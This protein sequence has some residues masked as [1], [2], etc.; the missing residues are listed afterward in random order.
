MCTDPRDSIVLAMVL[1][2]FV[3]VARAAQT[4]PPQPLTVQFVRSIGGGPLPGHFNGPRGIAIDHTGRVFVADRGYC[5]IQVFDSNGHFLYMWGTR[6]TGPGAFQGPW[7]VALDRRGSVYVTDAGN[8]R[9]QVFTPDGTFLRAFGAK[10]RS[11][12]Q[13]TQPGGIAIDDEGNIFVSDLNDRVQMFTNDGS[14][15]RA[16]GSRGYGDGQFTQPS[17][18]GDTGPSGIAVGPNGLV[19]VADTW[20]SRVQVFAR[21]GE[22][23]GKF[24]SLATPGGQFNTP[25]AIAAGQRGGSL[26]TP[27]GLAIDADGNVFV[28]NEGRM[29]TRGAYN[30]QKFAA[31]GGFLQRWGHDGVAP[32]QFDGPAGIAVDAAGSFYVADTGNNRIQKFNKY[33]QLQTMW[34]S[35]GDGLL[36][37]P[38]GLAID[39]DGNLL[40][41]DQGNKQVQKFTPEGRFLARWGQRFSSTGPETFIFP[42]AVAADAGHVYVADLVG[43]TIQVF[44]PTGQLLHRWPPDEGR[45]REFWPRGVLLHDGLLIAFDI[46]QMRVFD[47]NGVLQARRRQ[48]RHVRIQ[49]LAIDTRGNVFIAEEQE[50]ADWSRVRVMSGE[51]REVA[52]WSIDQ[53]GEKV[54]SNIRITVDAAGRVFVTDWQRCRIR[55]FSTDGRPLG[56]WGTCGFENGQFDNIE[57]VIVDANGLVYVS[58]YLNNRVQVFKVS[59]GS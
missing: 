42:I 46:D 52:R 29:R 43:R 15:V 10:G 22:F 5:R 11:A 27:E 47:A 30:V 21:T 57:D 45:R 12:G 14:F 1:T 31:D 32:G 36:R 59:G 48:P 16:W 49:D 4:V 13:F 56:Q 25:A 33:G 8:H 53:P 18:P 58:D 44:D 20:N 9:V 50:D 19:Y 54:T 55:I 39:P 51:G 6:G 24:G 38:L 26:N 17:M 35:S 34:G 40:V 2:A 28:A 37:N 41:A 23:V 3:P 7:N